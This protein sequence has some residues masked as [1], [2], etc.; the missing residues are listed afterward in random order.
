M[1]P[2]TSLEEIIPKLRDAVGPVILISGVG[3]LLLTMTNR[4]GRCIDRARQ[5]TNEL[6][7][8]TGRERAATQAQVDIIYRR[9]KI[10]RLAIWFSVASAL[11]AAFL[12]ITLFLAAWLRWEQAWPAAVI[13]T[14][15][16]GS[17]CV[18]LVAVMGDINLSLRALKLEL[19]QSLPEK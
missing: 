10:I 7:A 19:E 12:V 6:A 1:L 13:F 9:A 8:Q 2:P 11:L 5:L 18:S 4:L 14:A 3:L 15:C 16:L 17:Q